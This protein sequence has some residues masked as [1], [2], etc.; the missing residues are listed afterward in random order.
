MEFFP[1][2]FKTMKNTIYIHSNHNEKFSK[3]FVKNE[4]SK[5]S[6]LIF[7][8][9]KSYHTPKN[10]RNYCSYFDQSINNLPQS[11]TFISFGFYFNK[12]INNLPQNIEKIFF[13]RYFQYVNPVNNLPQNLKE[14]RLSRGNKIN[15][16]PNHLNKF[17]FDD[18]KG[19][20]NNL[21]K[22]IKYLALT[23]TSIRS[24]TK[25]LPHNL[26]ILLIQDIDR[27]YNNWVNNLL[28]LY[29]DDDEMTERVYEEFYFM[30]RYDEKLE[31]YKQKFNDAKKEIN[32][33]L[34]TNKNIKH[35]VYKRDSL[36]KL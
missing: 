15:N 36:R 16:L 22:S 33:L 34:K 19:N 5:C 31:N 9:V 21:P 3:E 27:D 14:F 30:S 24:S 11:I 6:N 7:L 12:P 17:I 35:K 4:L 13:E 26:D 10:Y 1:F 2:F 20:L 8:D 25:Y 18:I 29:K 32:F 23:L 28:K